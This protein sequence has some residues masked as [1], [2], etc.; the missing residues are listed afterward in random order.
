MLPDHQVAKIMKYTPGTKCPKK[1][2]MMLVR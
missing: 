2:P 1:E